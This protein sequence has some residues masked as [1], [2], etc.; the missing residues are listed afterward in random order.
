MKLNK[1]YI[2]T[3]ISFVFLGIALSTSNIYAGGGPQFYC[4][5]MAQKQGW[6][7]DDT[8][9]FEELSMNA[10]ISREPSLNEKEEILD[11]CKSEPEGGNRDACLD[12]CKKYYSNITFRKCSK[13]E[14]VSI[15]SSAIVKSLLNRQLTL[16]ETVVVSTVVVLIFYI[17]ISLIKRK[18]SPKK[19]DIH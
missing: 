11:F 17:L 2:L 15:K 8:K 14:V 7:V 12:K 5:E 13:N 10:C 1:T 3:L 16:I 9:Y 19:R 6:L 4:K 18:K